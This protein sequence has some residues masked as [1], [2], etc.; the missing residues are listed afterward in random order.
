ML[1]KYSA[2]A[3]RVCAVRTKEDASNTG[4]TIAL[5]KG[6]SPKLYAVVRS[7]G[8]ACAGSWDADAE[9]KYYMF[10]A[11]KSAFAATKA[12]TTSSWPLPLAQCSAAR[13]P[14]LNN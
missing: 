7:K 14:L 13:P 1:L 12:F 5:F 11:V 10:F 2:T 8:R 6:V 4:P 3:A 9:A